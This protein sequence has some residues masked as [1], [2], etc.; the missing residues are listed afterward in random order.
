MKALD[1]I[2]LIDRMVKSTEGEIWIHS[3]VENGNT[4]GS[5]GRW[6]P[7]DYVKQ[8]GTQTPVFCRTHKST[9]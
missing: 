9:E 1:N 4:Q 7:N 8:G 5:D 2:Q 6:C 3:P